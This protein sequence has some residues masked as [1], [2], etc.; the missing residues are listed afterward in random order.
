M[1]ALRVKEL[2]RFGNWP[3][4]LLYVVV[5]LLPLQ[6]R[7]LPG[8]I[9]FMFFFS[10]A[11]LRFRFYRQYWPLLFMLGLYLLHAIGWLYTNHP[12]DGR[13]ELE[14]KASLIAF[15][16]MAMMLPLL[17]AQ[18][19]RN[20]LR[21]F[22][23]GCLLFAVFAL[24]YGLK[25]SLE[26]DDWEYMFY[27]KLGIIFHP[28]YA[29]VYQV[30]A[31]SFL[32]FRAMAGDFL[33]KNK[34]LHYSA[35]TLMVIFVSMLSSKAGIL[36]LVFITIYCGWV[37]WRQSVNGKA[38][39]LVSLYFIGISL[40]SAFALPKSSQR[41]E[42]AIRTVENSGSTEVAH[43]SVDL[44]EVAWRASI[45]LIVENPMGVGTGNTTPE[46]VKKYLE[47]GE[48]Y[49]A[50]KNLNSHNQFLQTTCEL[51]WLGL[52][53]LLASLVGMTI[54]SWR[55]KDWIF[56]GFVLLCAFNFLFESFLEVQFGLVFFSLW[57]MVFLKH[58]GNET[59]NY[60]VG[61]K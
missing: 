8:L 44:R 33:L 10:I 34:W 59:G 35:C 2:F 29:A 48:V 60:W 43:T 50:K 49:A 46:L 39:I 30:F 58:D 42:G 21:L 55:K 11:Q 12:Y 13:K 26:L 41:I 53:L 28:T 20:L 9:F 51:G 7:V 56:L 17:T 40:G 47:K 38:P 23:W 15:P 25:R 32:L 4:T 6:K 16:L 27:G 45:E 36:S 18:R 22:A 31:L 3:L 61:M 1:K 14:F 54:H 5:F 52:I 37:G 19:I 24:L 57:A